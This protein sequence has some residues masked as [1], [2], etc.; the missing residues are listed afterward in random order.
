MSE[1]VD[2][3]YG[4][5]MMNVNIA[6]WLATFRAAL[7]GLSACFVVAMAARFLADHY[8]APVML[9]ALLLGIA[10][11]FLSEE[12][13]CRQGIAV[14]SS[15]ILRVG[16]AL[17]GIRIA[18][19][20]IVT[21]GFAPVLVVTI[22]SSLTVMF[23][24]VL[25]RAMGLRGLGV[26]T[27]GAVAICGASA[28][29]AISAVLPPHP[30]TERNTIFTVI[31]VTTLSTMTMVLYPI[32]AVVL[33]LSESQTGVFLGATIHDVAQVVGAG[34][35]VSE[36][37]G[38]IATFT[39]LLRVALLVPLVFSLSLVIRS[40]T[41]AAAGR[42]VPSLP[43]FLVG[44][45]CLIVLNSFGLFSPAVVS[46]TSQLSGWCLVVAIAAL[47]M[48]TSFKEL[49]QIG[50]R[51]IALVVAETGFIAI[52]CLGILWWLRVSAS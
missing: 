34:Y 21:L 30:E 35:S 4:F 13:A 26:L 24:I 23:G 27:G 33:G 41:G 2:E 44:F 9:F 52:L 17:L 14:A 25:A 12:G 50:V 32:I 51:P 49:A 43:V 16:V 15:T 48:K 11:H 10:F 37:S 19:E 40:Q 18:Y 47:G 22:G 38:D 36:N 39:K 42:R 1:V 31:A 3:F 45:V 5:K 8:G 29:L 6:G 46:F 20:D 28:A 7:P